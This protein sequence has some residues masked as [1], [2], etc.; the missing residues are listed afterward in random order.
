MELIQ[1]YHFLGFLQKLDY[2]KKEVLRL[3]KKIMMQKKLI[4]MFIIVLSV[5]SVGSTSIKAMVTMIRNTPGIYM[6][7]QVGES[8]ERNVIIAKK[9]PL[10][11]YP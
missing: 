8:L 9:E 5:V 4:K 3:N 11:V 1:F 10:Y 6:I 7:F 2:K